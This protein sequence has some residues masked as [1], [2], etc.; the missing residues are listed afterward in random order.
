MLVVRGV[1]QELSAVDNA[2]DRFRRRT[3]QTRVRLLR[4]HPQ[5]ASGLDEL[6]ARLSQPVDILQLWAHSGESGVRLSPRGETI[7][8]AEIADCLARPGATTRRAG[9]LQLRER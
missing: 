4:A 1:D 9:R 7:A 5:P 3:R 2:F 8:V 6:A